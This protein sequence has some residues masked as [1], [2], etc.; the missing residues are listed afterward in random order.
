M[1]LQCIILQADKNKP[2][3]L[4][5]LV[6]IWFLVTCNQGQ[7]YEVSLGVNETRLSN[8]LL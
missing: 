4:D 2:F 8:K 7:L 1:Y 5:R 6:S 3:K